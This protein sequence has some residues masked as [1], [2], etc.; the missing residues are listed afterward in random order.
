MLTTSSVAFEGKAVSR[1]ADGFVIFV[2]G[3]LGN[4]TVEAEII[5]VKSSFAEARL[6]RVIEPSPDR[7]TPIC[8]YFGPCG[9]CALQHMRYHAQLEA[10]TAQVCEV[11]ERIGKISSP[12]V[13]PTLGDLDREYHYRNKMEYSFSEERWLTAEEIASGAEA[14][15]FA[16]G[17]H[18]R[19]R[20]DRVLDTKV[21]FIA[22]PIV[23]RILAVT[24][25]FV[26]EHNLRVFDPD[27]RPNG[28]LRFLVIRSSFATGEVMAN[29]VTSHYDAAIMESYAKR[30]RTEITE[31]TTVVNNISSRRAQVAQGE[32]EFVIFGSGSITDTIGNSSYR[33]SANSFFQTNTKQAELLYRAGVEFAELKPDDVVWDLYC[34]AGT[35][36]LYAA[37]RVNRVLGIEM[38]ESA[39]ADAKEN[40]VRNK[41]VN[42]EFIAGDLR[43][44][45]LGD[46]IPPAY[47]LPNAL[48]IDP[49]RSGMH[50]DVV[51]TI[52][53]VA[54]ERISYISCNPATQARDVA[55][56][57]EK[58]DLLAIQPVDMFPQTWHIE[59]V[60]KLV[61]R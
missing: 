49:P 61:R 18:V 23:E 6:A 20:Y 15:R 4:E 36:A 56:L 19:G 60:A 5:K 8:P 22:T 53:D 43:K 42:A 37:S 11:F 7:R 50:P 1:R 2:E 28:L 55:L 25:A 24:R 16:L 10:K 33:I 38:A 52:L 39:I 40:A 9:G 32:R 44:V 54:P 45:L 48:I 27:L 26:K 31:I 58:Y 34:G 21:C 29:I 57:A 41:I 3:A 30:L 46:A 35:I 12:P 17:L 13:R 51:R 14:D 59:S 47:H